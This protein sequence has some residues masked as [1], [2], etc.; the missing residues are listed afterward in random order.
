MSLDLGAILAKHGNDPTRLL[1][2]LRDV[3]AADGLARPETITAI[4]R[5]LQLPRARVEGV[6]GFYSFL[7]T[8]PRGRFRVLFSDNIVDRLQGSVELRQRL[9]DAFQVGLGEVSRDGLVSID[10]TSC[11]GLCDQGPAML[12]N[13]RAIPRLTP[14]RIGAISALI[15]GRSP[16]EEWPENMFRIDEHVL[17]RDLLLGTPFAPGEAL[18]AAIDRG[19]A[20]TIDELKRAGLRGRGGAGFS[21]ATKWQACRDAPGPQR[22]VVCN[23]DEGEP[24]TFKDRQLLA[25]HADLVFEGM[26]VAAH[27]VGA[28]RGFLYLRA[29]YPFLLPHLE[30]ALEARRRAGLL[31]GEIRGVRGFAFDIEIH[32]GAGA[33]VCGEE[34]ALIES[35]EGKRGIPRNRPPY[36][37]THGYLQKPTVVNNVETLA[38]AALI[39]RHGADWWRQRGTTQSSGT[40]L[41]SVSGDVARPG[42]YEYPLGVT[43]QQ[44]LDDSGAGDVGAVQ[45][46]GPS[47]VLLSRH[48]LGRRIAF[49]DVP[50]AG[51][52]MVFDASRDVLEIV[53]DFAHFFAHESCGFCTPCRVG[54]T[55]MAQMTARLVAGKGT[56]RDVKDLSRVAGAMKSASHCGLGATAGNPVLDALEKFRPSFD[57]RVAS[58]EVLPTFDL[59][60]ALAPAREVTAREDAGAHFPEES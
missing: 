48:E 35:L 2:I 9:L 31:G 27:A 21:T 44:V 28:Q 24:G 51:A 29:E 50:S 4:A 1:Q 12:V 43:V 39:A 20:R 38:A 25:E 10:V 32:V 56:R 18:S 54:T 40:K 52:F 5:A 15:R 16:V 17:R 3:H 13:G 37:V 11:T 41:L 36:P 26:T 8:E 49:E 45:V 58:R 19:A 33:Y 30:A 6:A 59:D 57:R 47:G 53:D 34:S 60:E 22:F 23:A 42:V 55:L 14:A 46:G 7:G